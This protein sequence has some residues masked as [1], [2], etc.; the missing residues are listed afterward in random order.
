MRVLHISSARTFSDAERHIVSLCREMSRRGHEMFVALRPSSEWHEM[1]A[2]LPPERVLKVSIRNSFGM[3]SARRIAR[4]IDARGIDVIHAHSGKDYLAANVVRKSAK[5]V[6]LVLTRHNRQPLKP[7]HRFALRAVDAALA[8][9]E[10][11]RDILQLTFAADRV[12]L[13]PRG[14]EANDGRQEQRDNN[15]SEFREFHGVPQD[16][17]LVAGVGGPHGVRELVL[18]AG[19]VRKQ[20]PDCYFVIVGVDTSADQRRSHRDLQRLAKVLGVGNRVISLNE[21]PQSLELLAAA[22]VF[23]SLADTREPSRLLLEAVLAGV[24]AIT[25]RDD[26]LWPKRMVA[27][28]AQPAALATAIISALGDVES[29]SGTAAEA[30]EIAR[31]RF[32]VVRMADEVEAVYT[33]VLGRQLS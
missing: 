32:S 13:V 15:R 7:F 21:P 1:V 4:F 17:P 23:V 2:F 12:F 14:V 29:A 28:A 27:A 22:D 3:F 24:P 30:R 18:A 33:T 20:L 8:T 26:G 6:R 11:V 9:S 19:E 16:A 25:T 31:E 10:D 5:D